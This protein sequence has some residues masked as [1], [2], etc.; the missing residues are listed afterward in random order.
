[1]ID[2]TDD[3]DEVMRDELIL[4]STAHLLA[5]M[6]DEQAWLLLED[7]RQLEFVWEGRGRV[8]DGPW[9]TP[10]QEQEHVAYLNVEAYLQPRFTE[11]VLG[12]IMPVLAEVATRHGLVRPDHLETRF[13]LPS[14]DP[15][16]WR[17]SLHTRF[18]GQDASNQARRE[19]AAAPENP[20]EDGLTFSN[21]HELRVYQS[22]VR[23]QESTKKEQT[24]AIAP[25][26]GVRIRAGNTWT[27]DLV[28]L[29]NGRAMLI[30]VDGPH[31]AKGHRRA[32]DDIRDH[33]WRRCGLAVRRV[34]VE[35]TRPERAEELD[36]Y[37]REIV[38]DALFR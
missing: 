4:G 31:H 3:A 23:L 24:F 28:L 11:Q 8:I 21:E 18:G 32:D 20:V 22:L 25:L 14:V 6:G 38:R 5:S 12:R 17:E 30:E 29:G 33:Q 37:L 1:M 15:K 19:R 2:E 34:P 26:P 10:E 36:N 9:G 27:P 13:A 16:S 7:V 35:F